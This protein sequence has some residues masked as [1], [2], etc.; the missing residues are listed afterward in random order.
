ML[1][2]NH[3]SVKPFLLFAGTDPQTL[4]LVFLPRQRGLS[5]LDKEAK[6][7]VLTNVSSRLK[8]CK[9]F[10]HF[11]KYCRYVSK[12]NNPCYK[13]F[14]GSVTYNGQKIMRITMTKSRKKKYLR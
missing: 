4:R 5:Y 1:K 14:H 8:I 7:L 6:Q 2:F 11:G 13:V 10:Q 12:H 9:V 3:Q